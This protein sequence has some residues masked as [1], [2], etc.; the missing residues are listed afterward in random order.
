MSRWII[1]RRTLLLAGFFAL[2]SEIPGFAVVLPTLKLSKVLDSTSLRFTGTVASAGVGYL[3]YGKKVGVYESKTSAFA[4]G[5]QF[6]KTVTGLQPGTKYFFRLRYKITGKNYLA[7][8]VVEVSTPSKIASSLF[9]I[10]ADPHMDENSSADVYNQTLDLIANSGASFLIDL[11]DIF[12][13]D[14]LADK[15]ES[16]IRDRYELMKNYYLRLK[17]VPLKI[18]LGNHDGE[19]GYSTF[20][21][22]NFRAEYF[23]DQTGSVAYF[24]HSES[25]VLHIGLDPFTYTIAKPTADGWQWTLGK[26]QYEWLTSTLKNSTERHKFVYIHHLLVGDAQSRGGVHIANFNE[27][28]RKNM[29]GTEGFSKMRPGWEKPIHQLLKDH[30]VS[31]VFKGHDHLYV[32]EELDG[33][34]YQTLPQPSH[35][36]DGTKSAIE[37][38]YSGGKIIG[39][40]GFLRVRTDA[41]KTQVDFV[42]YDGSLADSYVV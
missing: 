15:S 36:G 16:N 2:I 6:S 27:W 31:I 30:G 41:D 5:R 35:P 10:Q 39:G 9:A 13:V 24:A 32:K 42:K 4:I 11:G 14:K 7:S 3:E 12:M 22:K 34:I 29:D 33:L 28:G 38:G 19:L 20:N 18:V 26:T 40:S 8:S 37:Y 17:G 1:S 23:P 21:T 25:D